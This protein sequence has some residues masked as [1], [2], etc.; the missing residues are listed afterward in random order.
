MILLEDLKAICP[1]TKTGR[2]AIFVEPL[3]EAMPEF[4]INT[5]EREAAFLAQAAHETM[6]FVH[7]K[8]IGSGERYEGRL[9]L[10]NDEPGEG[11]AMKGQGIFQLTGDK[12]FQAAGIALH[13]D[14]DWYR[15]NPDL[16]G[17]PLE[18]CRIA[19]WY[20]QSNSLNTLADKGDMKAITKRINGGLN[21]Y[22]DRLVY[23]ERAKKALT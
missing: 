21:G 20:W 8:E 5:P 19:G 23:W 15:Y 17:E 3:N 22:G 9:D 4:E 12:N 2:L 1:Q 14:R 10:G 13:G 7:L 18:A 6:G 16:A 11:M